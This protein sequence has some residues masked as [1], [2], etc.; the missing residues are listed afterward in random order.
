MATRSEIKVKL[1]E[2][3][4][5][6]LKKVTQARIDGTVVNDF[7]ITVV[8]GFCPKV[9]SPNNIDK[10][11]FEK[12]TK[13]ELNMVKITIQKFEGDN[14]SIDVYHLN[15]SADIHFRN[16]GFTIKLEINN[17]YSMTR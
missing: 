13:I 17:I 4:I 9:I 15:G 16:D 1:I 8:H 14:S 12:A 2:S 10:D 5:I 3:I 11:D 6:E 7:Q